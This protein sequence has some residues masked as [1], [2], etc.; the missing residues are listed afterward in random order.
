MT[1]K[2][3]THFFSSVSF[4]KVPA[5]VV[6]AIKD[7][8][9]RSGLNTSRVV[10]AAVTAAAPPVSPSKSRGHYHPR[11]QPQEYYKLALAYLTQSRP[12]GVSLKTFAITHNV[13]KSTL[14]D[15]VVQLKCANV[16]TPDELTKFLDSLTPLQ[17]GRPNLISPEAEQKAVEI[18]KAMSTN[19]V[20]IS[21]AIALSVIQAVTAELRKKGEAAPKLSKDWTRSWLRRKGWVKRK[22]T[23]AKRHL[24]EDLEA[25]KKVYLETVRE[26]VREHKIRKELVFNTDETGCH[27]VPVKG[28][29]LAPRGAE[30]VIV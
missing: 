29:T 24:P 5:V 2:Q 1:Q 18:L 13:P 8:A 16:D 3:I 28:Y 14:S 17:A 21:G 10:E 7:A 6:E 9:E 30:Q 15:Y 25:Q 20:V 11:C 26:L 19:G 27:V 22:A 23:T 12:G 4:S